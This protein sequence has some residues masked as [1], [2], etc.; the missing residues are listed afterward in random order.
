MFALHNGPII[1]NMLDPWRC[2]ICSD[3]Q[4]KTNGLSFEIK[5]CFK[6]H[7]LDLLENELSE[8]HEQSIYFI[9]ISENASRT[10]LSDGTWFV[11]PTFNETRNGWTNYSSCFANTSLPTY[12]NF[13]LGVPKV[14]LVGIM[15]LLLFMI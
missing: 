9:F 6:I 2:K 15:I 1:S 12:Q 11:P 3:T 5:N 8:Y 14:V 7:I 4:E 13:D 10:C